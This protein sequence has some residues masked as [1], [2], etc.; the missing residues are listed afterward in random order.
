LSALVLCLDETNW[1]EEAAIVE[2]MQVKLDEETQMKAEEKATLD[3]EENVII[4]EE[5]EEDVEAETV[6][7]A[8]KGE[9]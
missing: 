8:A 3:M 5:A 7:Q 9:S 4:T 2:G 1:Y 6:E